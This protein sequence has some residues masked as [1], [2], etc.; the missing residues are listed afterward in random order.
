M[1]LL[2]IGVASLL[3][4]S[5]LFASA[6]V[7]KKV[8]TFEKK[9]FTQNEGITLKNVDIVTKEILPIKG[10]YGYVINIKADV[11]GRGIVSAKDMF[12][13]NGDAFSMDMV[14]MKTGRSFKELL[15]PK[16][17]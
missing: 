6:D 1:K 16:I 12:F 10:W 8:I 2:S 9:R 3:L 11:P 17:S 15:M 13:S 4:S 7:D 5:A 14:N